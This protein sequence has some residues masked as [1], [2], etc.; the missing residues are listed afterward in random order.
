MIAWINN[1]LF[2]WTDCPINGK[3]S[4]KI[5]NRH[6]AVWY[7]VIRTIRDTSEV[8]EKQQ[9]IDGIYIAA[10]IEVTNTRDLRI[11]QA[12]AQC[13]I[14]HRKRRVCPNGIVIV[15]PAKTDL[16]I[17]VVVRRSRQ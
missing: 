11:Y 14:I 17:W 8:T 2:S 4:K 3:K 10:V 1:P 9:K 6:Y 13:D 5:I 15:H 7:H 12:S 16:H